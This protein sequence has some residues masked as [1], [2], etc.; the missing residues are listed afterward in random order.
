MLNHLKAFRKAA[1]DARWDQVIDKTHSIILELLNWNLL[2]LFNLIHKNIKQNPAPFCSRGFVRSS[3]FHA[4]C[5][6]RGGVRKYDEGKVFLNNFS[7]IISWV[8]KTKPAQFG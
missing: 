5:K 7:V 6:R 4:R 2:D 3:G 1:G 8:F